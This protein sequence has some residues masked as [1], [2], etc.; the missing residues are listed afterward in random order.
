MEIHLGENGPR[1]S[2]GWAPRAVEVAALPMPL[3]WDVAPADWAWTTTVR[4]AYA[5][6]RLAHLR[7]GS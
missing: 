4:C 2:R 3:H 6:E 7:D 5:P 1:R